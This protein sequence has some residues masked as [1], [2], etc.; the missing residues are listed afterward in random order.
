MQTGRKGHSASDE[1]H[2][3]YEHEPV[4][5][6]SRNGRTMLEVEIVDRRL[7]AISKE[8]RIELQADEKHVDDDADLGDDAQ[9]VER[10]RTAGGSCML[11]ARAIPEGRA[12]QDSADDLSD[13]RWLTGATEQA[14]P[15]VF[16]Q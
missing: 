8:L 13:Y 5:T 14:R 2:V 11:Q 9:E 16:R 1:V 15:K 4:P 12:Q 3:V 10:S 7:D 6:P